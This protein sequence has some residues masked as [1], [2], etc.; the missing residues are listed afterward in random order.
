MPLTW[1][2]PPSPSRPSPH[3]PSLLA[4]PRL[5]LSLPILAPGPALPPLTLAPGLVLLTLA[6][7]T[8]SPALQDKQRALGD[9]LDLASYLLKP[10]QRMGKYALLLQDLV[11]EAGRWPTCEP[12]LA[13]LRA[14]QDVVRSQLRHGNDLLAMDAVRGCDVSVPPACSLGQEVP[15]KGGGEWRGTWSPALEQQLWGSKQ[16]KDVLKPPDA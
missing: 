7:L 14:A 1:P 6:P 4:Q 3:R 15:T 13:E 5:T 2:P 11:R 9:K 8:L 16:P 10:V 12:E